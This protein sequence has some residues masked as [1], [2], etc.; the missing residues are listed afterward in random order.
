MLSQTRM[1]RLKRL[2]IH[3]FPRVKPGTELVFNEGSNVLLGINGSGKTTLLKLLSMVCSGVFDGLKSVGFQIDYEVEHEEVRYVVELVHEVSEQSVPS[4]TR[5]RLHVYG[6]PDSPIEVEVKGGQASISCGGRSLE[7]FESPSFFE[8]PFIS[9]AVV[10]LIG[11]LALEGMST[12]GLEGVDLQPVYRFDE[13]LGWLYES[14][15]QGRLGIIK[16]LA[17]PLLAPMIRTPKAVA[18]AAL[19]H[20][21][22]GT[23]DLL[24]LQHSEL[25][26]LADAVDAFGYLSATM[27]L[28]LLEAPAIDSRREM[29]RYG[30]Y[31]FRFV[32]RDGSRLS[33]G[34]LSFG[35]Q[36]L[37]AFLYY[38]AMHPS[39][40]I[41]D[42]LTNGMHHSMIERCL[43][44]VR[45]RQT[46]LATQNP[47]LLDNL[48][49]EDAEAV[50]RTF[51]LCSND[52]VDGQ[53]QM[54]WRNMTVDEAE[55]FYRDYKVGIS[56]V[57]DILRSWG[58]W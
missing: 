3:K 19:R 30:R 2:T 52:E 10:M 6:V 45:G 47:L 39:I 28:D 51:I 58:L 21:G 14:L 13:S 5:G 15:G 37:F 25:Q 36:R 48:E 54:V 11:S 29:Y 33:P 26:F 22:S 18:D 40:V 17:R 42:E 27:R 4:K 44:V 57:N 20:F 32:K 24:V 56:H 55:N 9:S 53:E 49:F 8:D 23:N 46:F 41:A 43:E 1:P 35:Q 38:S 7:G 31:E 50:R 34:E 12:R 16:R